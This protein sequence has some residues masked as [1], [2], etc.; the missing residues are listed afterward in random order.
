M[1]VL[2]D[3]NV[4]ASMALSPISGAIARLLLCWIEGTFTVAVSEHVMGELQ[5][6]IRNPWFSSRASTEDIQSFVSFVRRHAVFYPVTTVVT[7]VAT[8]P[9][10]DLILAA[11]VSAG[12]AYLVTGDRRF[13]ARVPNFQGVRLVSP[14]EFVS[15]LD[16]TPAP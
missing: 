15:I 1:I 14:S 13:R 9:E 7:G 6:T 5:R 4:L 16:D 8:H 2:L 10:D 3:A 12:A 11:A